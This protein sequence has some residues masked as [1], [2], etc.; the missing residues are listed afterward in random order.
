MRAVLKLQPEDRDALLTRIVVLIKLGNFD[1]ALTQLGRLPDDVRATLAFEEAYCLY[2]TGKQT[3]ALALL[4]AQPEPATRRA[5][6]LRAQIVRHA[7]DMPT[8]V[9]PVHAKA[10]TPG[11]ARPDS[12]HYKVEQ[13]AEASELLWQLVSEP[14]EVRPQ[15]IRDE[16]RRWKGAWGRGE[17]MDEKDGKNGDE[18]DGPPA[19]IV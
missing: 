9:C 14:N 17:W 19:H 13:Y 3:E 12:Q 4:R 10:L 5:Q 1:G 6:I 8:G 7:G 11:H 15:R 16:G 18:V 2:R